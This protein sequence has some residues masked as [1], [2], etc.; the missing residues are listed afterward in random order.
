MV[1]M[2]AHELTGAHELAQ[3]VHMSTH[4]RAPARGCGTNVPVCTGSKALDRHF[5]RSA[6]SAT[7]GV[8]HK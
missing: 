1:R 4:E 5:L 3:N 8:R 6:A 2:C 7:E